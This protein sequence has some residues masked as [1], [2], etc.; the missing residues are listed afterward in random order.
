MPYFNSLVLMGH[1]TADPV[2]K[3]VGMGKLCTFTLALNR[4][5]K[6]KDGTVVEETCFIDVETWASQA[7]I[8]EKYLKKGNLVLLEGRLKQNKWKGQDGGDRSKHVMSCENICLMNPPAGN[9]P[10]SDNKPAIRPNPAVANVKT[11][12]DIKEEID[13]L[14]F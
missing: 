6:R 9:T 11:I 14:P 4:K 12:A 5:N 13:D 1:L 3:P 8:A 7:D 2:S 10:V